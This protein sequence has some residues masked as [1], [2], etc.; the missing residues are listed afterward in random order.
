[1]AF[2]PAQIK[3]VQRTMWS[4]GNY[5]EVATRIESAS[6][7]LVAASDIRPGQDV[8]FQVLLRRPG[9]YRLICLKPG[10]AAKGMRAT[11]RVR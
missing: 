6:E 8:G 1:M 7:E 4:V 5:P 10:H 3:Q 2:D 11:L 9:V